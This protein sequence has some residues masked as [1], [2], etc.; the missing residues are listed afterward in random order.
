[1]TIKSSGSIAHSARRRFRTFW[2]SD[3]ATEYSSRCGNRDRADHVQITVA[4]TIGVERR[5]VIY[6]MTVAVRDMVRSYMFQQFTMVAMEPPLW[7]M[8]MPCATRGRKCGGAA[9]PAPAVRRRDIG[10]GGTGPTRERFGSRQCAAL[11]Q[12]RPTASSRGSMNAPCAKSALADTLRLRPYC[13]VPFEK[14]KNPG[15][16]AG[17]CPVRDDV[18]LQHE[19]WSAL[20]AVC[21]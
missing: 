1:M 17:L 5:R 21:I 14:G 6:R 11:R 8:R 2:P 19:F 13:W 7:S 3:S 9:G 4:G 16:C 10:S 18:L 12:P 20:G 15:T